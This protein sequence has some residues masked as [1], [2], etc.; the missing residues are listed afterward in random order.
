MARFWGKVVCVAAM[1][2]AC[3]FWVGAGNMN[4]ESAP[5]KDGGGFKVFSSIPSS[6][7]SSFSLISF[8]GIILCWTSIILECIGWLWL[9]IRELGKLRLRA[10]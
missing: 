2:V 5:L 9:G 3:V 1:L 10:V 8:F 6:T 7:S 4:L